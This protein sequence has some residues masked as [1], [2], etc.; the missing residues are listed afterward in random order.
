MWQEEADLHA[1]RADFGNG[2][3]VDPFG[4]AQGML[5]ARV[6]D[7]GIESVT[8]EPEDWSVDL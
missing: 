8:E 2:K 1:K 5:F 3:T 7:C 6:T 4:H